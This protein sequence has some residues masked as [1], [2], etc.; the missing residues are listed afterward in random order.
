LFLKRRKE[1]GVEDMRKRQRERKLV[2]GEE[3]ALG[4][5]RDVG[6]SYKLL[7]KQTLNMKKQMLKVHC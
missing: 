4:L 3:W 6:A 7:Y 5:V 1:P 2:I